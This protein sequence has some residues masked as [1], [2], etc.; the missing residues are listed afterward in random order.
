MRGEM[1]EPEM[2][3]G[4]VRRHIALICAHSNPSGPLGR[5]DT[6]GMSVYIREVSRALACLG[7]DVDIFTGVGGTD[8][9]SV[10]TPSTRLPGR[11]RPRGGRIRTIPVPALPP[12]GKAPDRFQGIA[13]RFAEAV[14]RHNRLRVRP[15]DVIFSHYWIS[16][17]AG[18]QAAERL[19]TP[20][21]V[22]FHTLSELKRRALGKRVDSPC[23]LCAERRV[24]RKS[25]C[26]IAATHQER[27]ALQDHYGVSNDRTVII[28]CGVDDHIFR[29]L[30]RSAC[31]RRLNLAPE[32]AVLLF[33][34]RFDPVKGLERLIRAVALV[35]PSRPIRLLVV[36]G[37]PAEDD[38]VWKEM[39][40]LAE[41]LVPD[42]RIS[43]LGRV[44]HGELSVYYNAADL[45]VVSSFY[46]SFGL[47][48]LEAMACGTPVV[49]PPVGVLQDIPKGSVAAVLTPDNAPETLAQGI[50]K[51]LSRGIGPSDRETIRA[52]VSRYRWRE[53]AR[54]LEAV[55]ADMKADVSI[56]WKGEASDQR[57][58]LPHVGF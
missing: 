34:G 41:N 14:C 8:E 22:M 20:H 15:Y 57:M 35:E 58:S 49:G 44:E 48:I 2:E 1:R 38:L 54:K 12:H 37:D 36:G 50:L 42:G 13:D 47:A 40:Q 3:S 45:Y 32:E 26:V 21:A 46:E 10:N 17:M 6:G 19:Q 28:P 23:R 11:L 39:T 27:A 55:F 43:F 5:R 24:A 7:H 9:P 56:P 4:G 25:R 31:R 30:D 33:V 18:V 16:G 51:G 29:P 53:T 52:V